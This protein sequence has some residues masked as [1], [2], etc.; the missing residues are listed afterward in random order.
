M[1]WWRKDAVVTAR[2][3]DLLNNF[4]SGTGSDGLDTGMLEEGTRCTTSSL[5]NSPEAS[6]WLF[7]SHLHMKGL[8]GSLLTKR[9][10]CNKSDTPPK[11]PPLTIGVFAIIQ[12]IVQNQDHG[13]E[14]LYGP[15]LHIG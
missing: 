5:P 2:H 10:W 7:D 15:E 4:K 8:H 12:V 3:G 1:E 14:F 9:D 11:G 13:V 6:P